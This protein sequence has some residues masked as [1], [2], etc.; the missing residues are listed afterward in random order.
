MLY[1]LQDNF[2]NIL[3]ISMIFIT[4]IAVIYLLVKTKNL[5]EDKEFVKKQLDSL[6]KDNS[7]LKERIEKL[8]RSDKNE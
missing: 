5:K 8:E 6:R 7:K 4:A 2:N 1:S 3:F